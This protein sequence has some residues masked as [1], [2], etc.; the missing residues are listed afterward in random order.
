MNDEYNPS[1]QAEEERQNPTEQVEPIP[2][3]IT[4]TNDGT[5]VEAN[6]QIEPPWKRDPIF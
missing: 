1:A 5:R 2:Y 4:F 6:F 3:A